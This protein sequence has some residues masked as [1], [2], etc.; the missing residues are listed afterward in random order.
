MINW[1]GCVCSWL[2][3]MVR[4]DT[5]DKLYA[6]AGINIPGDH[7][8]VY[9]KSMFITCLWSGHKLTRVRAYHPKTVRP[10]A[11]QWTTRTEH[12]H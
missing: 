1:G 4:Y 11:S 9:D 2:L 7:C 3:P 8:E 6:D 12:F 5:S 10:E